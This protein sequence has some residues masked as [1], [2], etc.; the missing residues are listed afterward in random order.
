MAAVIVIFGRSCLLDRLPDGDEGGSQPTSG[1][2]SGFEVGP[3]FDWD[4]FG[5]Y[6]L[7]WAG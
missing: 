7:N 1:L 2:H 6:Y 4:F 5:P 3:M